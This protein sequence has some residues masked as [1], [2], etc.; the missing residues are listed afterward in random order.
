[1]RIIALDTLRQYSVITTPPSAGI[2]CGI[3]RRLVWWHAMGTTVTRMAEGNDKE[4]VC[5]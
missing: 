4:H 3:G 2:Y 1:M 5:Y